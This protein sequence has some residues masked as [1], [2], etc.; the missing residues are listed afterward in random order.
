V[1]PARLAS[2]RWVVV[3]GL[4]EFGYS[5]HGGGETITGVVVGSMSHHPWT[6]RL[7]ML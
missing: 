3:E 5:A 1:S 2:L 7:D 6:D 4:E